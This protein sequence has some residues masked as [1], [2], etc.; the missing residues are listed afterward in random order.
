MDRHPSGGGEQERSEGK[1]KAPGI[2]RPEAP[3][4]HHQHQPLNRGY[5]EPLDIARD[6]IRMGAPV[7]VAKK[8]QPDCPFHRGQG[9]L[10]GYDLP[11]RWQ[12]TPIDESTLDRYEPG[13]ALGMVGGHALDAIDVDP[14]NAG[15]LVGKPNLPRVYAEAATPS[16]GKHYIIAS[17]GVP[18][19]EVFPGIDLQAGDSPKSRG[20]IWIAPTMRASKDPKDMGRVRP[21]VW[22]KRPDVE[23]FEEWRDLD[24]SGDS[25]RDARL[26]RQS[27][28]PER[29]APPAPG[30]DAF[31]ANPESA[32]FEARAY[33]VEE[34]KAFLSP[35]LV[36]LQ[37]AQLGQVEE[38][39]NTAATALSHFVPAFWSAD[40][41]YGVLERSAKQALGGTW[42]DGLSGWSLDKFRYVLD[43]RRP[44]LDDWKA[45]KRETTALEEAVAE[46]REGRLKSRLLRRSE[47]ASIPKP[48]PLI[49]DVLY[50]ETIAVIAGKFGTYK[51]FLGV[52][53]ACS[54]A[55]GKPWLR[56]NVPAAVPVLYIAAEG[57]TGIQ[58]RV[59]AWESVHGQVSDNLFVLPIAARVNN[60]V[61]TKELREIVQ[62]HAVQV[63]FWDT[64]HR[65]APGLEENSATDMGVVVETLSLLREQTGVTS[66]LMHHTGHGGERAR[67]S[68][69][70]ED[71]ADTAFV[72]QLNDPEDRSIHNQRT[73]R[74]RKT[75][76]GELVDSVP[77]M[78]TKAGDSALI[79]EGEAPAR[80][81]DGTF[82]YGSLVKAKIWEILDA[83][84]ADP[85][86]SKAAIIR[87]WKEGGHPAL[88]RAQ[89]LRAIGDWKAERGVLSD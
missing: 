4:D 6:L 27:K 57:A 28:A 67:G 82:L 48:M 61:D 63:V 39:A 62:E 78:L 2:S 9:S 30:T 54:L 33:T 42:R 69:A 84:V 83:L 73:L 60:S 12:M 22:I 32:G 66:V 34:A 26:S 65:S 10:S 79:A 23:E 70:I 58:G 36:A 44:P 11:P 59:D 64:L 37:L 40:E 21:Y 87:A 88:H 68:S 24:E 55:T 18:K 17:L 81:D 7:F 35:S 46:V 3:D 85:A 14:Q 72:V 86:L 45:S 25:W 13:D 19:G 52:A 16:G 74:H 76:D 71:D 1:V 80:P 43:G 31:D 56:W 29:P 49:E 50:R 5:M 38:R 41:A 53:M 47:L 77:L 75:K 8:C 51:S 15:T 20:F 89:M